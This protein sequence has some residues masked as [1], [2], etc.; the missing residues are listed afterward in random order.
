LLAALPA[1]QAD[2]L[3]DALK[4]AGVPDAVTVGHVHPLDDPTYL[5]FK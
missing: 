2:D 4:K 5:I 1:D 3:I